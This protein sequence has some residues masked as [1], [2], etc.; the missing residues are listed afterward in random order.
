MVAVLAI[1]CPS[2]SAQAPAPC[3]NSF[4]VL[5]YDQ[6]G[7]LELTPGPY[8][9]TVL[10]P[11]RADLRR[12]GGAVPPVPRGLRRP[13]RR[14]LAAERGH[15]DVRRGAAAFQVQ[16]TIDPPAPPS[17]RECPSYFRVLHNDHI[18]SL[19]VAKGRYRIVLLS[20]GP[21]SCA[22]ASTLFAALP[23]GLRRHPAAAVAGRPRH[24]QLLA[25]APERRLPDRALGR[26]GAL[27]QRLRHASLR[28]HAL[29]GD[30][31]RRSTAT[32]SAGSRCGPAPTSSRGSAAAARPARGPRSCSRASSR[33]SRATCRA[34]GCSNT[35]TGTFR[36]GPGGG[37]FRIKPARAR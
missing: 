8:S 5:H 3:P 16:R 13:A 2:A 15:E 26:A 6:I 31:P 29:P 24:R 12:R 37:G 19:A 21:I 23:P 28:R 18:G 33:T 17:K 30:V 32:A 34:H 22:R 14:R 27:G 1:A 7:A 20:V 35:Q 9:I 4:E 11:G 36:R 10:E 25:R